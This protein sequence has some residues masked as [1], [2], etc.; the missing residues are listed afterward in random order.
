VNSYIHISALRQIDVGEE[1]LCSYG[2]GYIYPTFTDNVS[3]MENE[4][5]DSEEDEDSDEVD[6]SN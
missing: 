1:I 4:A 6:E 3:S 2:K 5:E